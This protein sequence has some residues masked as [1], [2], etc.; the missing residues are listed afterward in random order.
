MAKP[1]PRLNSAAQLFAI[2]LQCPVRR[3]ITEILRGF[4]HSGLEFFSMLEARLDWRRELEHR[5]GR[6]LGV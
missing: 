6:N 3:A 1:E 2:S 4:G 5:T